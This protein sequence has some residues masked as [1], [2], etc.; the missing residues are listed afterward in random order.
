MSPRTVLALAFAPAV[1]VGCTLVAGVD[2]GAAREDTS[3]ADAASGGDG[4]RDDGR[5]QVDPGT[6]SSVGD[7]SSALDAADAR[8]PCD[9]DG[10]GYLSLACDGSDCDDND[11]RAHPGT[12]FQPV[13]SSPPLFGD[14]NC[15]GKVDT[16]YRPNASCTDTTITACGLRDGFVGAPDCGVTAPYITCSLSGGTCGV[17]TN[18]T[19]TQACR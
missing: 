9:Q 19:R 18:T 2:F 4:A 11:N 5:A 17:L 13:A 10:D 6:D 1:M 14:W 8:D 3:P 7:A 16:R 12:T 15:D